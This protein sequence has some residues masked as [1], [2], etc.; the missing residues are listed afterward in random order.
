MALL[1]RLIV[2]L[3]A[4]L[5]IVGMILSALALFA[6]HEKGFME[7]YAIARL[8]VSMIGQDLISSDSASENEDDG[9]GGF[10]DDI[11]DTIGDVK[12]SVVDEVNDLVGGAVDDVANA[13]G[14]S[15]WYSIHVMDACEGQYKPNA[16][17]DSTSLNITDC[18]N[19]KP[20]NRFNMTKLLD[21]S[22]SVGPVDVSLN[23]LGYTDEIQDKVDILNDALLGL[24]ILYVLG[25]GFCGVAICG[26]LGAFLAPARK[27]MA[28][29]NLIA[30]I[31]ACLS[32]I[33]ASILVT[34]A[35]TKGVREINDV[36]EEFGLE[37][38]RGTK[39]LII[40]WVAAGV[41]LCTTVFWGVRFGSL[42]RRN[43]HIGRPTK[44]FI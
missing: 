40:S 29:T 36:G 7:E 14:I 27:S 3:P 16:T 9:D 38:Q 30:S 8:N 6:G 42:K 1:D 23:D 11:Q 31:L 2:L 21:K 5:S 28:L 19:S 33:I 44:S 18:T 37:V 34:V 22:I 32:L 4:A 26:C 20:G 10:L 41:M 12:D 24:F 15:D 17:A 39:F 13:L 25:M 43:K 35:V